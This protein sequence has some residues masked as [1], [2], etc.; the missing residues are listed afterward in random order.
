MMLLAAVKLQS[1]K[2]KPTHAKPGPLQPVPRPR[3]SGCPGPVLTPLKPAIKTGIGKRPIWHSSYETFS[4][5][6]KTPCAL[7]CVPVLIVFD[8]PGE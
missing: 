7:Q 4:I 1:R 2:P 6:S 5:S 8:K 3:P